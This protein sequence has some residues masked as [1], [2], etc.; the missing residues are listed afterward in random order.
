MDDLYNED[1]WQAMDGGAGTQDS[2]MW[3]DLAFI[4][5]EMFAM[6]HDSGEDLCGQFRHV[7]VGCGFGFMVRH[8]RKRGFES[9]G[10]DVSP[11]TIEHAPEDIQPH[12][13]LFDFAHENDSFFGREAFRLLTT[14][15]TLEHIP[16]HRAHYA[17]N[18]IWSLLVPGGVG[19]LNI[20]TLE[21]PG[22]DRDPTHVNVVPRSW[23]ERELSN[24]GFTIDYEAQERIKWFHL[25]SSYPGTFIVRKP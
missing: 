10:L 21:R 11:W 9:F 19:L 12:L 14:F 25:F 7:D 8:M 4:V 1:Y 5:H 6:D 18:H 2:V 15:E 13:R 17:I 23:W 3:S 16:E 20:C 24:K 22:W